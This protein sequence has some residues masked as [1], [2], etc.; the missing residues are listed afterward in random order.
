M[1]EVRVGYRVRIYPNKAQE[2]RLIKIMDACRFVYNY[3][4]ARRQS[5]YEQT[6][7]LLT[8]KEMSKEL[9]ILRR[10][11]E[12]MHDVQTHP[13]QQ[14]LRQLDYAFFRFFKGK[15]GFP[16]FKK[17]NSSRQSIRKAEG[18]HINGNR[19]FIV[20]GVDVRFRGKFPVK[21]QGTLTIY[22]DNVGDWYASTIGLEKK[23]TQ[24]LKN[25]IGIDLGLN[26]LIIT[27][28]GEKYDN[29]KV[30]SR[31]LQQLRIVAK[32]FSRTC[33][34]SKNRAKKKLVLARYHRKVERVRA[35]GL[36]HISKTIVSKNH[37]MIALED[38][39]VKNM[40]RNHKLSKS[41]SDAS[42]S[43]LVRQLTYKQEWRGGRV[44]KINRFFPSSK[45][46]SSCNFIMNSMPLAIRNWQCPNC[47]VEHDRDV[48]A[49]KMILKKAEEQ[50]S[51]EGAQNNRRIRSLVKVSD[52]KKHVHSS[53]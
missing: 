26:H 49:A 11:T 51:A 34:G 29:P 4:L 24:K 22:R 43:E 28:N 5:V 35:N 16:N 8:N 21:N 23:K 42:W 47:N 7:E 41:I 20:R 32:A 38:L 50:L 25:N 52:P 27:S 12:W 40:M 1:K 3:F 18:W 6:G 13:L 14:S 44:V 10:K 15:T 37:A 53:G 2:Q 17:K 45:T 9:T 31:Y 36:H 19:I 39:G 30:L 48:N 33:K 46:C